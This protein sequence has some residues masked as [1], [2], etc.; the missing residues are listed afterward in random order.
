MLYQYNHKPNNKQ[1]INAKIKS[2]DKTTKI[3][4]VAG[5]STLRLFLSQLMNN[6]PS[7]EIL[8]CATHVNRGIFLQYEALVLLLYSIHYPDDVLMQ[9][10]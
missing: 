2:N 9:L 8:S 4:L 3:E 6:Q 10:Y 1:H 5:F 7:I